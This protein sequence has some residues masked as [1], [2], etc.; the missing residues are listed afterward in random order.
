MHRQMAISWAEFQRTLPTAL[1]PYAYRTGER[2]VNARVGTGEV[3]ITLGPTGERRLGSLSLP[4]TDVRFEFR[5]LDAES[6]R[7]FMERFELYFRR[8]GG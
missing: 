7:A 3:E 6:R 2:S 1:A 4:L 8:G 5:D